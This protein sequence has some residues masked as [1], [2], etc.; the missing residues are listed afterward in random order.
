MLVQACVRQPNSC[1]VCNINRIVVSID[2]CLRSVLASQQ[3]PLATLLRAHGLRSASSPIPNSKSTMSTEES[4]SSGGHPRCVK[5]Q[6]CVCCGPPFVAVCLTPVGVEAVGL[7]GG[8]VGNRC[9]MGAHDI[10][11]MM[12]LSLLSCCRSFCCSPRPCWLGSQTAPS[13]CGIA[14]KQGTSPPPLPA[15]S[16]AQVLTHCSAFVPSSRCRCALCC[17]CYC[18]DVVVTGKYLAVLVLPAAA[19][20]IVLSAVPAVGV[21]ESSYETLEALVAANAGSA[22]RG[23]CWPQRCGSRKVTVLGFGFQYG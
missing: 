4:K 9:G 18:V 10:F 23:C 14:L 8:L 2:A 16:P 22:M 7:L 19:G 11:T 6:P 3:L 5:A 12:W 13:L 1:P 15:L 21:P 17:R 20:R